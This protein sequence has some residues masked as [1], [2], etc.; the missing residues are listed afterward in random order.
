MPTVGIGGYDKKDHR[1]RAM[2]SKEA[3]AI[4]YAP[5]EN[6]AH[7]QCAQ[8][9]GTP[10]TKRRGTG[11]DYCICECHDLAKKLMANSPTGRLG[12]NEPEM[13]DLTR[14]KSEEETP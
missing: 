14:P 4:L 10:E 9:R 5:C 11:F 6:G 12:R 3:D 13:Q 8:V 1:R 7:G 2:A